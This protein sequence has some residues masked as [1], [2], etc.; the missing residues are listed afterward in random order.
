MLAGERELLCSIL[1]GAEVAISMHKSVCMVL[2]VVYMH[3][4]AQMQA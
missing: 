3:E 2:C 1:I 4:I